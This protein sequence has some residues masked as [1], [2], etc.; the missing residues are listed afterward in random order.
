MRSVFSLLLWPRSPHCTAKGPMCLW[1]GLHVAAIIGPLAQ[2]LQGLSLHCGACGGRPG[3][4]PQVLGG[5]L[6]AWAKGHWHCGLMGD[7]R[8]RRQGEVCWRLDW[9]SLEQAVPVTLHGDQQLVA[10]ACNIAAY[11]Q[12]ACLH[13]PSVVLIASAGDPDFFLSLLA[14]SSSA[15]HLGFGPHW[16]SHLQKVNHTLKD[17]SLTYFGVLE[18][19]WEKKQVWYW[20]SDCHLFVIIG[21]ILLCVFFQNFIN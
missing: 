4:W 20:K 9:R 21:L 17:L 14:S 3:S 5:H 8:G 11:S 7:R 15:C 16:L 2:S 6:A 19:L 18:F 13:A 10:P 1:N 12:Q